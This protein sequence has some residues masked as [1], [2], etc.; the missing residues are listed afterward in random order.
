MKVL[1]ATTNA[2]KLAA[3]RQA[4]CELGLELIGLQDLNCSI[5][6]IEETGKDPLEN[7]CIKA[8]AYFKAFGMPVFSCDSGLYFEN[9]PDA[10]QPGT[11]VRRVRGKELSDEEMIRYYA[12]LAADHGGYLTGR[13]RNAICFVI[14][15]GT[16]YSSMSPSLASAPFLLAAAPHTKRVPGFPLDALSMDPV[17]HTYYYDM[18]D[19]AAKSLFSYEGFKAFFRSILCP[20]FHG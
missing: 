5:P 7:A 15:E 14:N 6:S 1:Y 12:A 13:Y 3:M 18:E 17:T 11:H 8:D 16:R 10:L 9:L 4:T 19:A 2:G 20:P